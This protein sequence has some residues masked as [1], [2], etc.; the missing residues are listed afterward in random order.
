MKRS[1][2][3]MLACAAIIGALWAILVLLFTESAVR[4][5]LGITATIA[6]FVQVVAFEVARAMARR[7]NVIAGWGIGVALRFVALA[8]FAF[9]AVPAFSLPVGAR[10]DQSGG[11]PVP[12][13]P[14]R[15]TLSQN[16]TRLRILFFTLTLAI[17]PALTVAAQEHAPARRA[18]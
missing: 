14:G 7:K 10:A 1:L 16:M 9:V 15:T 18:G 8:V 12:D 2:L 17:L 3:F 5:A 4:R 6:F 13:D 11:V